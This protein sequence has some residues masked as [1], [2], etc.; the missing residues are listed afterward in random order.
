MNASLTQIV[1][2][3]FLP[4]ISF[5]NCDGGEQETEMTTPSNLLFYHLK[6]VTAKKT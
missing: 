5:V 2:F 6:S 3:C 1:E 4:D